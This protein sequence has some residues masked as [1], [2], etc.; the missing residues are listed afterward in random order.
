MFPWGTTQTEP[1]GSDETFQDECAVTTHLHNA[2]CF[3]SIELICIKD[4]EQS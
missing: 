4:A 2:V 1:S 3:D